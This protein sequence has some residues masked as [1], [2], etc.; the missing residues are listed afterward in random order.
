MLSFIVV[1]QNMHE[2]S[3]N[4]THNLMTVFKQAERATSEQL[5]SIISLIHMTA[6]K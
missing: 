3:L 5:S 1:V 6:V 2:S 4:L